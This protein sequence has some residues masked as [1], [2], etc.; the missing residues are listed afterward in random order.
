MLLF[1][2]GHNKQVI[3]FVAVLQCGGLDHW[4]QFKDIYSPLISQWISG[5]RCFLQN[6]SNN[7]SL[8]SKFKR[9][10]ESRK[11][12]SSRRKARENACN[13]SQVLHLIGCVG[14]ASFFKASILLLLPVVK[15][16]SKLSLDLANHKP[17]SKSREPIKTNAAYKKRGK[18]ICPF[19]SSENCRNTS[20]T[21]DRA[22]KCS[23]VP[24]KLMR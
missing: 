10:N 12:R 15:P 17:H 19:E 5:R 11:S 23:G 16:K 13:Q 4:F 21:I 6:Q 22:F 3:Q 14:G 2:H 1:I 9:G 24:W 20:P 8:H 7:I 18:R